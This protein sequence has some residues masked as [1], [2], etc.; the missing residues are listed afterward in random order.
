M[1]HLRDLVES[2]SGDKQSYSPSVL[3]EYDRELKVLFQSLVRCVLVAV[4][5]E[6]L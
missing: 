3:H 2:F 4:E 5:V 6:S 1:H